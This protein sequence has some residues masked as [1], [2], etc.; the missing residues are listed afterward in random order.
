VITVSRGGA[1]PLSALTEATPL[2]WEGESLFPRTVRPRVFA[3]LWFLLLGLTA[4]LTVIGVMYLH[5]IGA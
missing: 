4:G 3:L 2:N 1:R 5:L